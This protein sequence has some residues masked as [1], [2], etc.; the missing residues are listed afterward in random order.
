MADLDNTIEGLREMSFRASWD[1]IDR[2]RNRFQPIINNALELLKEQQPR[3]V[4]NV[5]YFGDVA[6][7]DCPSCGDR[8]AKAS[9]PNFCGK[10]GDRI[11]WTKA[12]EQE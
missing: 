10:C 6:L 12:G 7:G 11:D 5:H 2:E 8:V 3:A 1:D 9:C 4:K